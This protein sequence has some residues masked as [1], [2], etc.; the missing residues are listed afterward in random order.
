MIRYLYNRQV[1]PPAPFVHVTIRTA[2]ASK[3]LSEYPAQIDPG[4]DRTVIPWQ[5]VEELGLDEIR[6]L[7]IGVVGGQILNMPTFLVQIEIRQLESLALEVLGDKEERFTLL[8]RDILNNFR[9]LLDGP[10]LALEIG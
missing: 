4:A 7:P 1:N 8:G 6:R 9:L 5:V 3:E 2:N 10:Q